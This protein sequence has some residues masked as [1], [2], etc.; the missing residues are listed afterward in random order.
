[1]SAP[2]VSVICL[3]HNQVLYWQEAIHSVAAQTYK[4]I[5][6]ILVDDA[7]TDGTAEMA[8]AWAAL[9]PTLKTAFLTQNQ[10]NCAAFNKGLAM[11]TGKYVIDFSMDDCMDSMRIEKQVAFFEQQD[12]LTGIVFSDAEYVD[13][14][15]QFLWN[16]SEKLKQLGRFTKVPQGFVFAD[17]LRTYFVSPPTMMFRKSML[18][19]LGGYDEQLTYEDFDLLVRAAHTYKLAF[20]DE[21]LTRVRKVATSLSASMYTPRDRHAHS[22]YLICRK[23]KHLIRN[24][25]E[26]EALC[27]RISHELKHAAVHRNR[28][29]AKKLYGLLAEL[30]GVRLVD[31]L[32]RVYIW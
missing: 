30:K 29:V 17:V 24:E 26:R 1:M 2:L 21:Q 5:E 31:W 4:H 14:H 11:T 18:E 9:R 6:I 23:A 22:T 13:A 7:S 15:G 10:G 20:Q 25:V 28:E 32:W 3:S 16:H 8:K 27:W 12:L 19:V